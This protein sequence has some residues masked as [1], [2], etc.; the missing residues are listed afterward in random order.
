MKNVLLIMG[1]GIEGTGNTRITIEFEEFLKTKGLNVTTL[2]NCEKKW[3][4]R[5][6]QT[7]DIIERNFIKSDLSEFI[8]PNQL[9]VITSVPSKKDSDVS[10][11]KFTQFISE[12]KKCNCKIIYLNVDHK[13]H[14]TNRNYYADEKYMI[15]FFE[16]C[17]EIYLHSINNDFYTKFVTKHNL[18]D[19]C[20]YKEFPMVSVDMNEL[21][22]LNKSFDEKYDKTC[23]FIG[24]NAGWKGWINF[25]NMHYNYLMKNNYS[26]CAEGIELSIGRLNEIF[27]DVSKSRELRDDVYKYVK[28]PASD[29]SNYI[30]YGKPI[31]IHGPY[32]RLEALDRVSKA[33]FGMFF[34][35]LGE[36]FNGPIEITFL[37]IVAVGTIPVIRKELWNT[38]K[39]IN[40]ECKFVNYNTFNPEDI[41]II[42]YDEEDPEKCIT[43]MNKIN[44]NEELYNEYVTKAQKFV[45]TY[46]DRS[47]IL[48]KMYEMMN[49]GN[50]EN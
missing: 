32:N 40:E 50:N 10:K 29:E 2:A 27:K 26:S 35:F 11:E 38:A 14:S 46:Y 12:L 41:G 1:R 34:T 6:S 37:E 4:R 33:K 7:N 19:I 42:V 25:R 15:R 48:N 18:Q 20:I 3:E 28:F 49:G 30:H 44:D 13:I 5:L 31:S 45:S 8:K 9:V 23:H 39:F 43:L 22:Y 24:R 47:I 16:M 36:N 21:K 17:D